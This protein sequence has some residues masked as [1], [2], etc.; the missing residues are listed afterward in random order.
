MIHKLFAVA[1]A[2]A[3]LFAQAGSRV[4]GVVKDPQGKSIAD[5]D[6]RLFRQGTGSAI[7]TSTDGK[8]AFRS[9]VSQRAIFCCRSIRRIFKASPA[10]LNC[11]PRASVLRSSADCR[12]E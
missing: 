5:A 12:R 8:V 10:T 6:I 4:D 1:L 11:R 9:S 2:T 7:R 3:S